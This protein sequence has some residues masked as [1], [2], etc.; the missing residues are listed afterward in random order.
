M[1]ILVAVA[2]STEISD[3]KRLLSSISIQTCASHETLIVPDSLSTA[4]RIK[5]NLESGDT[6]PTRV[7]VPPKKLGA[8]AGRNFAAA[9]SSGQLLAFL[10]GDV[11]LDPNWIEE[12]VKAL[13]D[14][15]IGGVSGMSLVNL[16]HFGM[17]YVPRV[18]QWIVGGCYWD[19]DKLI[20]TTGAAGMNFCV[21]SD[22]FKRVGG[23]DESLGPSGERPELGNWLRLGAE[24][25]DLALRI[26]SLPQLKVI[27][28]PNMV[29]EHKLRRETVLPLGLAKRALHVGHNRA[30][31]LS[32][33]PTNGKQSDLA[34]AKGLL[35]GAL[36]LRKSALRPGIV[37][38]KASFATYVVFFV[39]V[40]YL[41]GTL[42]YKLGSSW[43]PRSYDY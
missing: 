43:N 10:D 15:R 26:S 32:R 38:K 1:S 19:S 13:N 34:V 25:S 4:L 27:F 17:A 37:W 28:N 7:L 3:L 11:V 5:K 40:G 14:S 9:Q 33:Y 39:G 42:Q 23:Y 41:I 21:K 20:P 24:E 2:E 12:G 22:V 6:T 36:R 30:F 18:L 16:G 35:V 29:V 8:S 31:I